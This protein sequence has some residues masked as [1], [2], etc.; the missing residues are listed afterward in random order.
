MTI[1]WTD[2][3]NSLF[4]NVKSQ[5]CSIAPVFNLRHIPSVVVSKLS[6]QSGWKVYQQKINVIFYAISVGTSG[7]GDWHGWD[8]ESC[9][10]DQEADQHRVQYPASD[11]RGPASRAPR[12]RVR[13]QRG[14]WVA[15]PRCQ[16]RDRADRPQ[17]GERALRDSWRVQRWS[18]PT[19]KGQPI[20]LSVHRRIRCHVSVSHHF[21]FLIFSCY[22]LSEQEQLD[23]P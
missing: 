21:F 22:G 12:A 17:D 13:A 23:N 19:L 6:S 9:L 1:L 3:T 7:N 8:R 18:Q 4:V 16:S 20:L 15:Q 5:I 10:Q 2:S 11:R 14:K